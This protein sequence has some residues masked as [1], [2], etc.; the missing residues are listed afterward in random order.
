MCT[1]MSTQDLQNEKIF[2][3]QTQTNLERFGPED[4]RDLY[5][6]FTSD[7]L[8][9]K[10]LGSLL[11]T[12]DMEDFCGDNEHAEGR[13]YGLSRM[14]DLY[15]EHQ[16]RQL[17]VLYVKAS[18]CPEWIIELTEMVY[19]DIKSG[20]YSKELGLKLT[21]ENLFKIEKVIS[22][23]GS[24]EYPKATKLRDELLRLQDYYSAKTPMKMAS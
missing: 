13:R 10:A 19:N 2:I 21:M 1:K 18:N 11:T 6:N 14:L 8:I 17:D 4:A 20:N 5:E 7:H 24:E 3:S 9:L 22:Q 23:F 15:V 16:Q 12:S